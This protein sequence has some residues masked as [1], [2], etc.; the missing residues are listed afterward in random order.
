MNPDNTPDGELKASVIIAARDAARILPAC[1][2]ALQHQHGLICGIDYNIIV[3]DD[4]SRDGTPEVARACGVQVL[5]Q[6]NAGPASARNTGVRHARGAIVVF[7][8]ADCI[9]AE[10]WLWHMLTPFSDVR[11]MGVKGVYRTRERGL[12]PRFVQLEYASKYGRMRRRDQ[13]DFVDTYAAAYRRQVFLDNNGFDE[14]FPAPSVE[15]QEFSFRLARKGYRLVFQPLAAVYHRHDLNLRE[16]CV[17]KFGIGFWKAVML[18]WLPEKAFSDSHTPLSQRLQLLL[19]AASLGCLGIGLFW[20][21]AV[22]IGLALLALF[23]LSAVPFL[24]YITRED[25][26]VLHVAVP[27]LVARAL[28]L[29]FGLVGGLLAPPRKIRQVRK[30]LSLVERVGKRFIDLLGSGLGL[31]VSLPVILL[32]AAAI[33]LDS[34]GSILFVQVRA[35]ENGRPF[36]MVKLRSMVKDAE[37]RLDE[38]LKDNPLCGPVYKIPQDARVTR[39]GRFMRRWSLDELPQFW[40]VLKGEMSLVGPRPEEMQVV[41]LYNDAQRQR[42]LVKPGMT[43]PMQVAGRGRLDMEARLRLEMDYVKNYSVWKDVKIL[44]RSLPAVINGDGAY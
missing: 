30:G 44:L 42:L 15:D 22:W 26:A 2:R 37:Q 34:P 23:F 17:R 21:P 35:G 5:S 38:V 10:D 39:V 28:A 25:R 40:N 11:V 33:R 9:P 18:N 8:D 14:I 16:Y 29:G 3:V 1:L 13:I 7:T 12:V 20:Y 31:L 24:G 19:M 4:G 36:K 27:L 43:G 6:R 32:L 41:N